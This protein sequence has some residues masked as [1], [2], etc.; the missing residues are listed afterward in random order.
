[1]KVACEFWSL[2][3]FNQLAAAGAVSLLLLLP[4]AARGGGVV[5]ECTEANLR[6]AMSGG[7][8][9]T[10]A[11]DGTITLASTITND[12]NTTLDGSGHQVTISGG[13]AV[14]VFHVKTNV[15]L[16]TIHL[17]IANG[18]SDMGAAIFNSGL[19]QATDSIFAGNV[20]GKATYPLVS[21][22]GAIYNAGTFVARRCA[23]FQN[24]ATGWAYAMPAPEAGSGQGGAIY[25][26]GELSV[27]GSA[28]V[29]NR[30]I[31]L[32]GG[33]GQDWVGAR[34]SPG[35]SAYGGALF[36][37]GVATL[38]NST[39]VSN[40]CTGGGGGWG[41]CG[42]YSMHGLER[43]Y[44]GPGGNGGSGGNGIGGGIY[45]DGHSIH[46]TNC[47][48]AFNSASAGLGGA[49]GGGSP[50]GV[51]GAN[52]TASG[53]V[54]VGGNSPLIN[55]IVAGNSPSNFSGTITDFGHNLSSDD[56]SAITNSSSFKNTNP[57]LG[58]LANNGGP[59]LTM[60]LLPGS[61]AIDAGDIAAAP[62]T[63][64]RGHPRPVGMAADIGSYEYGT[65]PRLRIGLPQAGRVEILLYDASGQT[66]RLFKS[67]TLTDWQCVA[68]NRIGPDGTVL[69][70]D[71]CG[72]GET[73]R[74]YRVALP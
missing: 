65:T 43:V 34:G 8:L 73:Q 26:I 49:G 72:T 67:T 2:M 71:N 64:Q 66:C 47:T 31:G 6:A 39:I 48:V 63:D 14:G 30:A 13:N 58:S 5:S 69:F 53:A 70:Q 21:S 50:P 11:C 74:F 60:A 44:Y 24:Q 40:L 16:T 1:M 17:T 28:F 56:S 15:L 45:S 68:T 54:L 12:L 7:G 23:F 62:S 20:V 57:L 59:T 33:N 27:D 55:S 36:N 51:A 25:N 10:F 52:G 38:V 42:P 37:A 32:W 35:G 4:M 19:V 46:L 9:V 41:G 29:S 61:P 22:G 3:R 18:Y